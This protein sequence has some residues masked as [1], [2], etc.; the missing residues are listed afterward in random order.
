[1]RRPSSDNWDF[2]GNTTSLLATGLYGIVAT[3]YPPC[4]PYFSLTR[5]AAVPSHVWCRRHPHL[6]R[7]RG[8]HPRRLWHHRCLPIPLPGGWGIAFIYI[9]DI[10]SPTRSAPIGWVLPSEI[11]NLG[12]RS[13][14]MAIT[15]STTW[16]CNFV[17]G[18]VTPDM[19]AKIGWGTYIFFAAFCPPPPLFAFAFTLFLRSR[20]P[21]KEPRGYGHR[22][23]RHGC[24]RGEDPSI[25]HCRLPWADR[26]HPGGKAGSWG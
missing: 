12:N 24:A 2:S 20:D 14:A 17:I 13:K 22:L 26:A 11:F 4:L 25:Q 19:L 3:P 16:I 18:L 10:N 23:W 21:R 15:T 7:H 8:R 1:M 5:S 6:A 9:Y